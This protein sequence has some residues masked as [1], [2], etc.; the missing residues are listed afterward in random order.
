MSM[1]GKHH[2]S[3]SI[4]SGLLLTAPWFLSAPV[5][6][7]I[8]IA[9]TIIGSLLPDTDAA[10]SKLHYMDGIAKFFSLIM[11]PV[12]FPLTGYV[13]YLLRQPFNP[14]HRGSMHTFL[15]LAVYTSILAVIINL[16]LAVLGFWN[17]LL[18]FF[19]IGLSFGGLFHIFDDCC[20]KSGICP[21]MPYS[22]HWFGGGIST[23]D[24]QD[25]RPEQYSTGLIVLA[26]GIMIAEQHFRFEPLQVAPFSILIFTIA[27]V[28]IYI[29]SKSSAKRQYRR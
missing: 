12:V 23:R 21:L 16:G 19:T 24:H 1:L 4:G 8:F 25:K 10:D 17:V 26:V 28:T 29:M 7:T 18:L 27:W 2:I 6:V 9:G 3:I 11:R 15:G 13:F 20:T 22:K 14:S 5:S